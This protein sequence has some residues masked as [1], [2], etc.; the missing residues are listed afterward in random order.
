M[1]SFLSSGSSLDAKY[2]NYDVCHQVVSLGVVIWLIFGFVLSSWYFADLDKASASVFSARE[3]FS[4]CSY[5]KARV[6][7]LAGSM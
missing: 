4:I 2:F 3:T 7:S 6:N 5:L 1:A